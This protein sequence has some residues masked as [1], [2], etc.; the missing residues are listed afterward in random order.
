M[1]GL[2]CGEYVEIIINGQRIRVV[3][4]EPESAHTREAAKADVGMDHDFIPATWD[5]DAT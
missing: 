5:T 3:C 4:G 1:M 2:A